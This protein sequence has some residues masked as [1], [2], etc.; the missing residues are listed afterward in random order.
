MIKALLLAPVNGISVI[1]AA[2]STASIAP[3]GHGA[4]CCPNAQHGASVAA[5]DKNSGARLWAAQN[6]LQ[7][8]SSPMLVTLAGVRQ[9]LVFSASRLIGVTPDR[10][11]LLSNRDDHRGRLEER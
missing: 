4:D 10:G 11:E 3:N 9:I 8:Y 6:D 7:S 2:L 1:L 5:Y